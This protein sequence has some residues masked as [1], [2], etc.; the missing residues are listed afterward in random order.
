MEHHRGRVP[1]R[2]GGIQINCLVY[3]VTLYPVWGAGLS[4]VYKALGWPKYSTL[5]MLIVYG[6][7]WADQK[8]VVVCYNTYKNIVEKDRPREIG[9]LQ[10]RCME[11]I[12]RNRDRADQSIFPVLLFKDYFHLI[13]SDRRN[14]R[15]S[16]V[17]MIFWWVWNFKGFKISF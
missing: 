13:N 5:Y 16:L 10:W 12:V 4:A 14:S 7:H 6:S 8:A 11:L 17:F 2:F 15:N 1:F 9:Y 3:S